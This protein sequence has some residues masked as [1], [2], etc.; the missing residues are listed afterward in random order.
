[1]IT[2]LERDRVI[3]DGIV[4]VYYEDLMPPACCPACRPPNHQHSCHQRNRFKPMLS[5]LNLARICFQA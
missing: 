1:M 4:D 3:I 2:L 5:D